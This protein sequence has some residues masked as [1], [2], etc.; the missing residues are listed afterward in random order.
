MHP[1][2]TTQN[3]QP[4]TPSHVIPILLQLKTIHINGMH[5]D[6]CQGA[7]HSKERNNTTDHHQL[8]ATPA[9]NPRQ[10]QHHTACTALPYPMHPTLSTNPRRRL[11]ITIKYDLGSYGLVTLLGAKRIFTDLDRSSAVQLTHAHRQPTDSDLMSTNPRSCL[12]INL[13]LT[14]QLGLYRPVTE[15]MSAVGGPSTPLASAL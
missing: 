15:Q 14:G 6:H 13:H 4:A 2:H 7:L 3:Q 8:V 11:F 5:K 10:P 12:A 1:W 9:Y